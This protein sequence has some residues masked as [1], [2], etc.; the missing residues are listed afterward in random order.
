ML[1]NWRLLISISPCRVSVMSQN[2][3]PLRDHNSNTLSLCRCIHNNDWWQQHLV[4]RFCCSSPLASCQPDALPALA[5]AHTFPRLILSKHLIAPPVDQ[6]DSRW[7]H[8]K[9]RVSNG[10]Y[11]A[12]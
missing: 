10:S 12:A 1:M 3:S 5:D 9:P 8:T 2:C 7:G 4:R 11:L 6:S